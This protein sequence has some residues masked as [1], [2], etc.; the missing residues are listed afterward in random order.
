MVVWHSHLSAGERL[1]SGESGS[2]R[3]GIAVGARSAACTRSATGLVVVDE[4]HEPVS[5]GRQSSLS[6]E[7]SRFIVQKL[8]MLSVCWGVLLQVWSP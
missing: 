7:T 3:D 1:D 2:R 6:A 4:E 8:I 5:A